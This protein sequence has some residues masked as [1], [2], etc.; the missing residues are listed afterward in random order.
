MLVRMTGFV[1]FVITLLRLLSEARQ[2]V[3]FPQDQRQC[4]NPMPYALYYAR[5]SQGSTAPAQV[6]RQACMS[7]ISA[8][9]VAIGRLRRGPTAICT[10]STTTSHGKPQQVCTP[11]QTTPNSIPKVWQLSNLPWLPLARGLVRRQV[12]LASLAALTPHA[13]VRC[14][15]LGHSPE[16]RRCNSL[17][18]HV[19]PPANIWIK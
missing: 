8:P 14:S 3:R 17:S 11:C 2:H 19:L 16:V 7:P 5:E 1:S 6:S 4:S 13:D 18:T 15:R 12:A 9:P 10:C